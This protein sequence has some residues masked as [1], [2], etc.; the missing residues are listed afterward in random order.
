V[1]TTATWSD[2]D[3]TAGAS[4]TYRLIAISAGGQAVSSLSV[5]P[6]SLDGSDWIDASVADPTTLTP[7]SLINERA[8]S[9]VNTSTGT[10]IAEYDNVYLGATVTQINIMYSSAW[11]VP[12]TVWVSPTNTNTPQTQIATIWTNG[13]D[14]LYIDA[15]G[16]VLTNSLNPLWFNLFGQSTSLSAAV[17]A[18]SYNIYVEWQPPLG[19][20]PNPPSGSVGYL[21]AFLLTGFSFA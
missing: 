11:N 12:I 21:G 3:V 14:L 7:D 19:P 13:G 4:Y 6:A 10:G 18:G 16:S 8:I 17:S 1:W 2:P 9:N 5:T 20:N 15:D